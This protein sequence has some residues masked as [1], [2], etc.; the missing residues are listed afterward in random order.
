MIKIKLNP[1]LDIGPDSN[2]L[3]NSLGSDSKLKININSKSNTRLK[4]KINS[5]I[6]STSDTIVSNIIWYCY[7]LYSTISNRTYVGI[8][9]NLIKR[10][11]QHN[12]EI[13]GGAKQ[14][15]T[16]R[17]WQYLCYISGFPTEKAVR[18]LEWRLHHPNG[19]PGRRGRIPSKGIEWRIKSLQKVLNLEKWT[20]EAPSQPDLKLV[21]QWQVVPIINIK[22][23]SHYNQIYPISK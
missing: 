9:N 5:P 13:V 19:K 17:P 20:A 6:N 8:T 18:Q 22:L 14:T 23:P 15:K 7:I 12:G 11:R 2:L 21:L 16:G 10:I 1:T 4:I 3:C